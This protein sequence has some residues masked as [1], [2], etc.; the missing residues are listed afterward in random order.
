MKYPHV[1]IALFLCIN[2]LL[3]ISLHGWSVEAAT[4]NTSFN[5]WNGGSQ[6]FGQ[7]GRPQEWVNILGNVSDPEGVTELRYSLNGAVSKPL[8]RG[9][10]NQRLAEAGDFNV[11]L[12]FAALQAGANT[13]DISAR[14]GAGTWSS[15]SVSVNYTPGNTWPLPYT[16]DW[17]SVTAVSD[18]AQIVDGQWSKE[19]DSIRPTVI[20]YDRLVALGDMDA[21]S[22]YEVVLPITIHAIDAAGAFQPPSGGP[23]IGMIVRW[24]GHNQ[25]NFEQPNSD[26]VQHGAVGW[27]RW[28][29][30]SHGRLQFVGNV[31][32]IVDNAINKRLNIG[33][34][35]IFKLRAE[36]IPNEAPLYSFKVW[37]QGET[38]PAEWDLTSRGNGAST[39]NGSVLLIAH[40]VDASFGDISVQPLNQ[41]NTQHSLTVTTSGSGQVQV[42]P[43]PALYPNG[44]PY[45]TWVT[46]T[47]V[48]DQGHLFSGWSGGV[49]SVVNPLVF[50]LT[51]DT[52]VTANF[53]ADNSGVVSDDF[54]VCELNDSLWTFVNPLNDVMLEYNGRQLKISVPQGASH[55][56]WE[57]GNM[58]P[59]IMQA[60]NNANLELE[61]KF[62]STVSE[63]Y[64][65]QG[66]IVEQD[67]NDFLRFDFFSDGAAT[68]AF[69]A[70]F[71]NGVPQVRLSQSIT[72]GQPLYLRVKRTGN[73]WQ[74]AY[75]YNGVNWTVAGTFA[76]NLNVT[77]VGPFI[78]N[79]SD[80][81]LAHLYTDSIEE[82]I[83]PADAP[84]MIG[85]IDYFFNSAAPITPQADGDKS[86]QVDTDGQG[87]VTLSP[88]ASGY[89]CGAVVTLTADPASGWNFSHWTGDV[90]GNTNPS[91]LT[92]SQNHMVT[93]VFT[94]DTYTIDA[95]NITGSGVIQLNP[96]KPEYVHGEEVTVTAV[97]NAGWTF[98]MWG[99]DMSGS[100]N[101]L[102][103]TITQNT[104]VQAHF[105]PA[106]VSSY[107]L[108]MP[109][110]MNDP[111]S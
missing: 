5:I 70:S 29:S 91:A 27:Y 14:D 87:T 60:A 13:L 46:L 33:G 79:A 31:T 35:Y 76:H 67:A 107:Q 51:Q 18:A 99:G 26:W 62:D 8:S 61:V 111:D 64:Q 20:D 106:G 6:S 1:R 81:G 47:A 97:P 77:A 42:S 74:Q 17:S 30:V 55:D 39:A 45:G 37:P 2:L 92:V 15:T 49:T 54:S 23:G 7:I 71:V 65:F 34:T 16:V 75:S 78:G 12:A 58:A 43:D 63:T 80:N 21:W 95:S 24:Q 108:Y 82:I 50:K 86:I 52:A 48:P 44:Y 104:N 22:D 53:A 94:P 93:A 32:N 68:T 102:T 66:L 90:S 96:D 41:P 56:V 59:R 89:G 72:G 103:F 88:T 19:A 83:S 28:S 40:H 3:A 57:N 109:S 69:A 100:V 98:S 10:D 73:E 9:P 11:E 4:V 110:I 36:S 101:P 105:S 25:E 85:V 38:E 84:A